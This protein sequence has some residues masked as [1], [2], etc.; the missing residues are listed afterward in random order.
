MFLGLDEA[1]YLILED[2]KQDTQG[3]IRLGNGDQATDNDILEELRYLHLY[4]YLP[5]PVLIEATA[6]D[7]QAAK[8]EFLNDEGFIKRIGGDKM[9]LDLFESHRFYEGI[10]KSIRAA[11]IDRRSIHDLAVM[12]EPTIYE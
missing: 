9:L 7:N 12:L 3:S 11:K 6:R 2:V 10:E 4:E 8:L 5:V 1:F